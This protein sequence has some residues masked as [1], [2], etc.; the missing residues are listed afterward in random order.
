MK[1]KY[2]VIRTY[3]SG[4]ERLQDAFDDGWEFFRASDFTP[5]GYIEY[6][7]FK[8]VQDEEDVKEDQDNIAAVWDEGYENGMRDAWETARKL[9]LT[10]Y[11]Y[12][13]ALSTAQVHDIF[14]KTYYDVLKDHSASEVYLKI[15]R[16]EEDKK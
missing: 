8:N 3:G 2:K 7:L 11:D 9:F 5:Q 15:K 1:V 6:I 14:G 12:E 13:K 4:I 10:S 16:F